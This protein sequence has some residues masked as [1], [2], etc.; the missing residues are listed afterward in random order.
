MALLQTG[1]LALAAPLAQRHLVD[2][3]RF[4]EA[5]C[6][7]GSAASFYVRRAPEGASEQS[8]RSWILSM[9]GGGGCH[10]STDSH[11]PSNCLGRL[12]GALGTSVHDPPTK[13]LAVKEILSDDPGIN[14]VFHDWNVAFLR[15]C[16]GSSWIGF[17]DGRHANH[18]ECDSAFRSGDE[19]KT[20][21]FRGHPNLLGIVGSLLENHGMKGA[22]Q[23]VLHGCA[24][25]A[26]G[27]VHMADHVRDVIPKETA[28]AVL[29]DSF[30]T[31]NTE[32][33]YG[34]H[35]MAW[36]MEKMKERSHGHYD[37]GLPLSPEWSNS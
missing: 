32:I 5:M 1:R 15:Y 6:L 23:V 16:D 27:A 34:I 24:A 4:P 3:A 30:L 17:N 19:C 26:F 10:I 36:Y 31:V 33:P 22:D 18:P 8:K 9:Q 37:G 28:L 7:D 13:D 12:T 14:P 21:H 2:Q 29:A 11:N 35:D 20:F 25:G